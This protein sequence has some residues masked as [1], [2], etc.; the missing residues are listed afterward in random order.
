MCLS[1][2]YLELGVVLTTDR[3]RVEWQLLLCSTTGKAT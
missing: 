1:I 2:S 3:F